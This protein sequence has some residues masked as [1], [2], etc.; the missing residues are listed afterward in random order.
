VSS[1]GS[2]TVYVGGTNGQNACYWTTAPGGTP[3]VTT[4]GTA[5]VAAV[6]NSLVVNSGTV[7]AGGLLNELTF[8]GGY[9]AEP[10]GGGTAVATQLTSN[11]DVYG[12]TVVSGT[13]YC[14]GSSSS[15][16]SYW[17]GS[18]QTVIPTANTA[19]S[20]FVDSTGTVYTCGWDDSAIGNACL[21]TGTTETKLSSA[22]N[23]RSVYVSNG[24]VYVAG[25][26]G[27]PTACYWTVSGGVVTKTLLG[28][29]GS[30]A[31]TNAYQAN[32]VYVAGSTVY[33]AGTDIKGL[34]CYW[35][36]PVAGGTPVEVPLTVASTST[37]N[38]S[39]ASAILVD[40][41]IIYISGF[42]V[43]A[44]T[45]VGLPAPSPVF[46]TINGSTPAETKLPTASGMGAANSI[47]VT[48]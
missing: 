3:V 11:G 15:G 16:P 17:T 32:S 24:V 30:S 7:Y 5:E 40:N 29:K 1:G 41:G 12:T 2:G 45:S 13:V 43:N 47:F 23:A 19:N 10:T 33:C 14:V 4:L 21:W 44:P 34:A 46:W 39:T 48:P 36:N 9:W 38:T 20:I 25:N 18:T 26:D 6:V 28:A 27:T 35:T 42:D 31:N 8:D 37:G 22:G